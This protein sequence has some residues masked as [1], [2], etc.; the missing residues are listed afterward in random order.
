MKLAIADKNVRSE[1]NFDEVM[2][3][4]KKFGGM[5]KSPDP[6]VLAFTFSRFSDGRDAF[7]QW[8]DTKGIPHRDWGNA[9]SIS[10]YDIPTESKINEAKSYNK[11][12]TEDGEEITCSFCGKPIFLATR[13]AQHGGQEASTTGFDPIHGGVEIAISPIWKKPHDFDPQ[14]DEYYHVQ[15]AKHAMADILDKVM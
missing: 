9:T 13:W 2:A 15:C 14:V 8:L 11:A 7:E 1:V 10:L 12:T 3:M 4:A 5:E 6:K